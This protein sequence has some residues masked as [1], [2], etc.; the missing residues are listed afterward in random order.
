MTAVCFKKNSRMSEMKILIL[1]VAIMTTVHAKDKDEGGINVNGQGNC[2]GDCGTSSVSNTR[3]LTRDSYNTT[4]GS[5]NTTNNTSTAN[6]SS[7]SKS[8]S[9]SNSRSNSRSNSTSHSNSIGLGVGIG[10][11]DG[12]DSD[13]TSSS[14]SSSDNSVTIGGDTFKGSAY[15]PSMVAAPGYSCTGSS[16]SGSAGWVGG[17]FGLGGTREDR[18][19]TKRE[20]VKSLQSAIL[21]GLYTREQAAR[22]RAHSYAILINMR[23]VSAP[24]INRSMQ[25]VR[26]STMC[27]SC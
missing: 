2:V 22:L 18:E 5:Y 3:H 23:E 14:G 15:A 7:N 4:N 20:T 10:L 25:P 19:C 13:S 24:S 16:I 6:L 21:T 11:A 9:K 8:N 27:P 17:A 12:G 26:T 1:V